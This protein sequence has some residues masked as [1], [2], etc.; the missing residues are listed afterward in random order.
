MSYQY[1]I[2]IDEEI[3][4]ENVTNIKLNEKQLESLKKLK[5]NNEV[6]RVIKIDSNITKCNKCGSSN[7]VKNGL[8]RPCKIQDSVDVCRGSVYAYAFKQRYRCKCCGAY[9]TSSCPDYQPKARISTP[10][11]FVALKRLSNDISSTQIARELNLSHTTIFKILNDFPSV[12]PNYKYLPE[13]LSIDELKATKQNDSKMAFLFCDAKSGGIIDVLK[14]R[15]LEDLTK[16]FKRY[17]LEVRKKVKYVS[18]DMYEPYKQL[19]K[20][21]FPNAEIVLDLFHLE[22]LV[23][24]SLNKTRVRTMKKLPT[25]STQ[26]KLFKN[27]WKLLLADVVSLEDN[28][29]YNRNLRKHVTTYELLEHI[30]EID[31]VLANTYEIYQKILECFRNK[32]IEKLK[33]ILEN[34]D[35]NIS[36]E[37]KVSLESYRKNIK[38]IENTMNVDISNGRIEGLNNRIKTINKVCYGLRSFENFR[39]RALLLNNEITLGIHKLIAG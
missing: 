23:N 3:K 21:V 14:S 22:Q 37:M 30:L 5:K 2:I 32:D 33:Y 4:D 6:Y 15:K 10:L 18:M 36:H 31:E 13:N 12:E 39:K 9:I 8:S 1:N 17:P 7:I 35:D 28:L 19:I 20:K 11:K 38:Y 24:R 34:A 29:R 16:Y 26:Y 25:K 27:N